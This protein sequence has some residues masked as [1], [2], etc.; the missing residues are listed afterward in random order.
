MSKQEITKRLLHRLDKDYSPEELIG[1]ERTLKRLGL[2][3][4]EADANSA[5]EFLGDTWTFYSIQKPVKL[6][7]SPRFLP[8]LAAW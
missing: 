1:E 6:R 8:M 5:Y 7:P 3:A 2:L 4:G